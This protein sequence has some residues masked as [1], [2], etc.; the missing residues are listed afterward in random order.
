MK[1]GVLRKIIMTPMGKLLP[2]HTPDEAN[3]RLTQLITDGNRSWL[4]ASELSR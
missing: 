4:P 2:K 1:Q 3:T